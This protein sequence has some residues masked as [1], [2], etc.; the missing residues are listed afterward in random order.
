MK[1]I[2][3]R[4]NKITCTTKQVQADK[5]NELIL[6]IVPPGEFLF[7]CRSDDGDVHLKY[8]GKVKNPKNGRRAIHTTIDHLLDTCNK[9]DK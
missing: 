9:E 1:S 5:A 8:R 3:E 4:H 6:N 7:I 2:E